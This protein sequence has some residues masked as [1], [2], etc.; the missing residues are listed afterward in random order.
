MDEEEDFPQLVNWIGQFQ[1]MA[2]S[3]GV[4]ILSPRFRYMIKRA[5]LGIDILSLI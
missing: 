2:L 3:A 5:Y 1:S 4:S